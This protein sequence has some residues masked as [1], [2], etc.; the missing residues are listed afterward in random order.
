MDAP[1]WGGL[2]KGFHKRRDISLLFVSG[3]NFG[4]LR[5]SAPPLT[6]TFMGPDELFVCCLCEEDAEEIYWCLNTGHCRFAFWG[7][8]FECWSGHV[9]VPWPAPPA[10]PESD[11]QIWW[12]SSTRRVCSGHCSAPRCRHTAYFAAGGGESGDSA[13]SGD[14]GIHGA[15]RGGHG[16]GHG[17]GPRRGASCPPETQVPH[18]PREGDVDTEETQVPHAPR[19]GDV[20]TEAGS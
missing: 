14:D 19:E 20:D 9:C 7:I 5:A 12:L 18:A 10:A 11:V 17:G 3:S 6:T 8:C 16:R 2:A 1:P 13:S 4:A 15:P